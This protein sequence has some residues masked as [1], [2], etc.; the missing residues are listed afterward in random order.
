[1]MLS[2]YQ[3]TSVAVAQLPII[4]NLVDTAILDALFSQLQCD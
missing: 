2:Q 4:D 1:M 3:H